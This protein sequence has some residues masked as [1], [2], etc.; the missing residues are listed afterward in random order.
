MLFNYKFYSQFFIIIIVFYCSH[1]LAI[2]K[3]TTD[4]DEERMH[5][6]FNFK[7]TE[8]SARLEKRALPMLRFEYLKNR[9]LDSNHWQELGQSI[10]EKQLKSKSTLNTNLAKNVIMFLGDG[11]SIPTLTAGRVYMGGEEKQFSFEEFPYMGLSKTYC[12]NTQVADSACTATAYLA[13]IK[14]NYATIGLMAAV[15][16]YD[17][18][19]QNNTAHHVSSLAAWAQAQGM[20]TGLITN[21]RITH[22]SP[23]GIFAHIANRNWEDD[24]HVLK[25]NGDPKVCPDIAHQMIYSAVGRKLNV[26]LGGG[27]KHFLP[28]L[29]SN[30][31]R[32]DG[33]NLIQEWKSL[34][35]STAH[36]VESREELFNLP[37]S[38]DK[39]LGLFAMDHLPYHLD[40][41]T[42]TTPS[43]D[44][45]VQVALHILKTQSQGKGYFLFVEGGRID[46]A[47]HDSLAMKALDETVEFDKAVQ[48][49]Q[50]QT[51]N[52]DTLIVVTSD[53]SH[54]MSVAGYSSRKNNIVGINNSQMG[55]DGLP[56]AT[57]SYA[58]GPGYTN[59]LLTKS[60]GFQRKNLHQ[61]NMDDKDYQFP[62]AVPLDS[63]THGGDDVGVF[64]KGPFAHLFTGVYEQNFIPH[65]IAYASCLGSQK[66]ACSDGL[67]PRR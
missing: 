18:A 63:E 6:L 54:T 31:S 53:H 24:G 41:D 28:E 33:R 15:S 57:L 9:E 65:A 61:V 51:S 16:L 12:V 7:A 42:T 55:L 8:R 39:L 30:G 4:D 52:D 10:L 22:A 26:I 29:K 43:L 66:T 21:T 20:A 17:C 32:L 2:D 37:K 36:Y 64:A 25:D 58:N 1:G 40:S 44:E 19:G 59:N 60:T 14:A 48:L 46:H 45:M 27:R 3:S 35:G 49:A 50:L 11:M 23:A 67:H 38:A 5:P 56:Y 13:G 47:H 62:S 34:H